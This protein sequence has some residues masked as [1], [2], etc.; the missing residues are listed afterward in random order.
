MGIFERATA[1]FLYI[2]TKKER[3]VHYKFS[4]KL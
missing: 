2:F 3:N 4:L 1:L